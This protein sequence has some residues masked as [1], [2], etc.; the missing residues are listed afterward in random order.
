[1]AFPGDQWEIASP[2]SQNVDSE[3]L[4]D[5]VRYLEENT[6]RDGVKRLVIVRHGRIIWQGPEADRRHRVWSVSKAF[7]STAHGLLD[8]DGKCTLETLARDHNP[9]LAAYYPA[10][11]LRH[12]ATMTSGIDGEGGS[13]DRDAEGR[14]DA[15]ALV[16]PARPFF[17]P[18]T[19]YQYWDE[20]TQHYG[21][22]LTK[23]AGEPLPDLLQRRILG[24]IGMT[25]VRWQQD[26]T[27]K[28]IPNWT[29]GLEISASDLARFGH[30]FLNRGQW[31]GKQLISTRWVDDAT[32]VQVP[33]SIPDALPSSDRKGSGIYGYH[34]WPNGT[35][36]DGTRPWP[37][38]PHGT[39]MRSGHNNNALF[40]VPAWGVVIV[41]LGLDGEQRNGGYPIPRSTYNEFLRRVGT[42]LYD[43]VVEGE[44]RVWHPLTV[45]FR[46]PAAGETDEAP[47]PFLDYRLT[48]TFTGPDGTQ[49]RVPGFFDGDGSGGGRG[50]IWRV[51]FTPPRRGQWSYIASFRSGPDIAVDL[52]PASGQP[53]AFDGVK[54]T[55][56]IE[57]ALRDGPEFL[58]YGR[59]EYAHGFYLKFRS[60]PY[61]IKGGTDEPEDLL[62]YSGFDHTRS[63]KFAV[64][65]YGGHVRDWQ[66]GDPDWG[67]GK[68]KGF[69]GALNYLAAHHVN[70]IYFMPMNIG[71][72]GQNVWPFAG[73]IDPQGSPDNDTTHYD[74]GKLRQ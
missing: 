6:P 50:D 28:N 47:N 12:L 41:R 32:S 29:G 4:Q 37:D 43:S 51:R 3:R 46:G 39:Y 44:A 30:L 31:N 14:G 53:A 54:G 57:R 59:L 40:V 21:F 36:P 35:R 25:A 62:A 26:D 56:D 18:G 42:A 1:M 52:N 60:G 48:V 20:A 8:D 49:L 74:L 66:P 16:E 19:K 55:L 65:D 15:N 61:W 10:V 70:L 24:P 11:N 73:R 34:W 17:P 22:V 9:Q 2:Q 23:I 67:G 27:K 33:P 5:A 38:A 72:D 7:T 13:Y 69:I 63:G 64:T 58:R 45:S 71:G 68:G